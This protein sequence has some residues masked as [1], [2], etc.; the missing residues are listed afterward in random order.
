MDPKKQELNPELKEIYDRVMNTQAKSEAQSQ[1][2]PPQ[3][4]QT[5]SVPTPVKQAAPFANAENAPT[6][7]SAPPAGGAPPGTVWNPAPQPGSFA[8]AQSA[9]FVFTGNKVTTPQTPHATQSQTNLASSK[10]ISGPIIVVLVVILIV[11]W[12]LFWAKFFGVI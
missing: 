2:A 9:P 6:A 12:A 4:L 7:V 11:M 5:T 3:P 8:S 10:K 1:S